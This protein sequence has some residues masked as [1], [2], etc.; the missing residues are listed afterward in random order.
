MLF[1]LQLS[2]VPTGRDAIADA[3]T[4]ARIPVGDDALSGCR[5]LRR[6][7]IMAISVLLSV[8]DAEETAAPLYLISVPG[9]TPP[10]ALLT[11]LERQSRIK[12]PTRFW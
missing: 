1:V 3:D 2:L 12:L 10:F 11:P 9:S 6:C 5:W 8:G 7:R 4:G